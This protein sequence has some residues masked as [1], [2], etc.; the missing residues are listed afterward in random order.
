[1]VTLR[2]ILVLSL[3]GYHSTV[4]ATPIVQV[5]ELRA[6]RAQSDELYELYPR[7]EQQALS[8]PVTFKTVTTSQTYVGNAHPSA[9]DNC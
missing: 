5:T 1:M 9:R 4:I 3:F 6:A 7:Q 8:Q 2:A